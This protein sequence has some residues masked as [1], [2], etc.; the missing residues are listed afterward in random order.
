MQGKEQSISSIISEIFKINIFREKTRLDKIYIDIKQKDLNILLED[1]KKS[2]NLYKLEQYLISRNKVPIKIRYKGNTYDGRVRLKG[3]R[4]DHWKNNKRFSLTIELKNNQSIDSFENFSL[5]THERRQYPQGAVMS[6]AAE[7]LGLIVPEFKS[8][9]ITF[10]GSDWGEMYLEELYSSAFYEKRQLKETPISKFTNSEKDKIISKLST[11]NIKREEISNIFNLYS[12]NE[13]DPYNKKKYLENT[14]NINQISLLEHINFYS[15]KENLSENEKK[16]LIKLLDEEKFIKSLAINSLFN[17][18]HSTDINNLRFYL[19]PFK[20]KVE[21]LPTDYAGQN[22]YNSFGTY[23]SFD[24]LMTGFKKLPSIYKLLLNEME[25]LEFYLNTMNLL[26]LD[27]PKMKSD[28][29]KVCENDKYCIES[30]NFENIKKNYDFIKK[31]KNL[32]KNIYAKNSPLQ[33]IDLEE[34]KKNFLFKRIIEEN[35]IFVYSRLY[36]NGEIFIENLNY[37][38]ISIDGIFSK[39]CKNIFLKNIFLNSSEKIYLKLEPK[40][41]NCINDNYNYQITGKAE[42]KVFNQEFILHNNKFNKKNFF[43]NKIN[44]IDN[45]LIY[46]IKDKE[47]I[48]KK[49]NHEIKE[50]IILYDKSLTVLADTNLYFYPESYIKIINGNLKLLGKENSHIKLSSYKNNNYWNGIYVFNS[51]KSIISNSII[52]N[53]NYF[54]DEDFLELTGGIN[55]HSSNLIIDDLVIN[56]ILSEDGINLTKSKFDISNLKISSTVSDGIDV[57]FCNGTINSFIAENI[58]GDAIDTSGSNVEIKNFYI[59][60]VKDKGI[61]IGE[62]SNVNIQKGEI[63]NSTIGIAIKDRSIAK[64]KNFINFNNLIDLSLYRK[65]SF[66]EFGGTLFI[67]NE[68]QKTLKIKKDKFS[69][70]FDYER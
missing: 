12:I 28:L 62:A 40:F 30:I 26:I 61:S 53:L 10:N 34:N 16:Q 52:E 19:N 31:N 37:F 55:F 43:D 27:I 14:V 45:N 63:S 41:L 13:I 38:P 36:K 29:I 59:N 32:L 39:D 9:K 54:K 18:W 57:D 35:E 48:L 4:A 47:I 66:Y 8:Y 2:L 68:T 20:V 21:P 49:G 69:Q 44:Q 22:H 25:F 3:D 6:L 7:R 56:N 23:K 58:Y 65:K 67:N 33:K 60:Q 46:E 24:E 51:D 70:V 17:D 42:N 50:P 1:R 15:N 5:T 11:K 64:I